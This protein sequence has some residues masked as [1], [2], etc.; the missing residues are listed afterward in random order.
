M[1]RRFMIATALMGLLTAAAPAGAH[2]EY[3]IIGT[4]LKVSAGKLDVKQTR[5]GK[6]ISMI[7]NAETIV[8][9]DTRKVNAAELKIGA[10]VVVDA[11]GDSLEELLV[12]EVK[13]VPAPA[14]R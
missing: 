4:V 8:T 14:K 5:D 9:R 6:T 7:T 3:R 13:L 2:D 1:T 11:L 10:N 12:V